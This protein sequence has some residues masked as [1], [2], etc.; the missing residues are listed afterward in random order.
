[1]GF[2]KKIKKFKPCGGKVNRFKK[3]ETTFQ[4]VAEVNVTKKDC[5]VDETFKGLL[6]LEHG[7]T[8]IELNHRQF[9]EE[10]VGAFRFELRRLLEQKLK[11]KSFNFFKKI[12]IDNGVTLI[13]LEV[14]K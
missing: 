13:P 11:N 4:F 1:V 14:C 2:S 10:F 8:V 5:L 7:L 3:M 6:S 12:F 9:D